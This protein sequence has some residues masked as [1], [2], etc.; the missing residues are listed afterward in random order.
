MH[1]TAKITRGALM[2]SL[3]HLLDVSNKMFL[4]PFSQSQLCTVLV[5]N[6]KGVWVVTLNPQQ[7]E[8]YLEE[9]VIGCNKCKI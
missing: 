1:S 9:F 2:P 8:F 3:G 6:F 4:G 7:K 5:F